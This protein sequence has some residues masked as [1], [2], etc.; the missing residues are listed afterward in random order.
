MINKSKQIANFIFYTGI[1][2]SALFGS[3]SLTYILNIPEYTGNDFLIVIFG[4]LPAMGGLA[5]AYM[6][7][8]MRRKNKRMRSPH[9]VE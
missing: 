9:R 6:G 4:I 3:A 2:I 1:T 5:L 8:Y 7:S